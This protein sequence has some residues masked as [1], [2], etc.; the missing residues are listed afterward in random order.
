[1]DAYTI[2]GLKKFL[3]RSTAGELLMV[4]QYPVILEI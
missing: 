4:F 1:M 3:S 2:Q